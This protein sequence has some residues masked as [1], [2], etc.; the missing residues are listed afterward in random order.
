MIIHVLARE[1]IKIYERTYNGTKS[2]TKSWVW[3]EQMLAR[4]K[5]KVGI[6]L[7]PLGLAWI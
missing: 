1:G 2:G 5:K 7:V 6:K 4:A 3:Y